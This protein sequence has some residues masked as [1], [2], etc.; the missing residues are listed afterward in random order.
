VEI[1]RKGAGR[2]GEEAESHVH[3]Q[4]GGQGKGGGGSEKREARSEKQ[5]LCRVEGGGFRPGASSRSMRGRPGFGFWGLG[6]SPSIPKRKAKKSS[7]RVM[8]PSPVIGLWVWCF[9]VSACE[10]RV[11]GFGFRFGGSGADRQPR[12]SM[13][14]G[15]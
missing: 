15:L 13:E 7:V 10:F 8:P 5:A 14:S 11:S 1:G 2:D 4:G 12:V 6:L 3:M 9:M